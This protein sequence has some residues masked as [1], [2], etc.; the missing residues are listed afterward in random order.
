MTEAVAIFEAQ[1]YDSNFISS[2]TALA[3]MTK[4]T[5]LGLHFNSLTTDIHA[6]V[7]NAATPGGGIG[8]ATTVT[9]NGNSLSGAAL[10]DV[11]TL[12][13]TYGVAVTYP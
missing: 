3:G 1:P 12:R 2:I 9:L 11:D 13:S 4:L 5:T 8:S 10:T 6:V 7:T